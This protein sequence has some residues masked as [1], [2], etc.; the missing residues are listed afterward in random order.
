ML[1]LEGLKRL[2]ALGARNVY[3]GTGIYMAANR[4]YE[5]I[6]MTEEYRPYQW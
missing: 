2:K 3:V 4:L 5:S 6:G 1:M